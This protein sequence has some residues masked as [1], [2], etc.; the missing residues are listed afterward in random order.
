MTCR[1]AKFDIR[2]VMLPLQQLRSD[3]T[4]HY[5]S[6][7]KL[8]FYTFVFGLEV[9]GNPHG[10]LSDLSQGLGDLFYDPFKVSDSC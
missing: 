6:Q 10:L 5:F 7:L 2:A 1:L 8:R 4:S 3:V 9:L